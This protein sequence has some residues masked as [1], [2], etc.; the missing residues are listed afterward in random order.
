MVNASKNSIC[1]LILRPPQS[2]IERRKTKIVKTKNVKA[3]NLGFKVKLQKV[4]GTKIDPLSPIRLHSH[5][6]PTSRVLVTYLAAIRTASR[7]ASRLPPFCRMMETKKA[8]K[9]RNRTD[10][11]VASS[12]LSTR[13]PNYPIP[14]LYKSAACFFIPDRTTCALPRFNIRTEQACHQTQVL[15][16]RFLLFDY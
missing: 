9:G 13:E 15:A 2:Y 5:P 3:F 10:T 7:C 16:S 6:D 4:V 8:N 1:L 11:E 14:A 12:L